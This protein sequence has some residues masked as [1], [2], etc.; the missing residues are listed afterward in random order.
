MKRTNLHLTASAALLLITSA[1]C[2]NSKGWSINGTVDNAPEGTKLA[3]EANH[4]GTWYVIDS[5]VVN[6]GTFSYQ[7]A[8]PV[9]GTDMMR[10]TLPGKGS[11]YFPIDSV[12]A[13][14]LHA[15]AGTY[16]SGHTLD[17]TAQA[18]A[19]AGIDSLVAATADMDLLQRELVG[20]IASD[21]TGIVAYYAVGK[22]KSGR[23][24]FDPATSFGNR[25]YGA[26]AQVYATHRPDDPRAGILRQAY[27]A[28][29]QLLGKLPAPQETL[30]EVPETGLIDIS[31]YDSY[32]NMQQLS[33]VAKDKVTI[34]SFTAY[35]LPS[36]PAYN[37]L[38]NDLYDQ[39]APKGLAIYQI[40]FDG[41]EVAWKE[42]ARNLPW[43]TV[44]NSPAD[45]ET[46][47]MQYNVGAVPLTYIISSHGE[48]AHR[49]ENPDD[50]P[51][52]LAKQF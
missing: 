49:V 30:V 21:T 45:G 40:S 12:D 44:W 16:G 42:A 19:F 36:S 7:S 35:A 48:I 14:T 22:A 26:A 31:R 43:T 24:V 4:T 50:L 5:L 29:R 25:A 37:A 32:G 17:G 46:V 39:Y 28:G 13:I 11:V 15:D 47:L 2:T 51:S 9:H 27:F 3:L 18:R 1:S 20:I 8:Q 52:L 34:L 6:G 10:L 38:L 33:N 41:D 23:S